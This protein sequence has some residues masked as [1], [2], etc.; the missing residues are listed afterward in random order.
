MMFTTLLL[1]G[2]GGLLVLG[3]FLQIK[4][5]K[6]FT[7]DTDFYRTERHSLFSRLF[8]HLLIAPAY[9]LTILPYKNEKFKICHKEGNVGPTKLSKT[10]FWA[11]YGINFFALQ[12]LL[13]SAAAVI[14][15]SNSDSSKVFPFLFLCMV[16]YSFYWKWLFAPIALII[17]I[18]MHILSYIY[19]GAYNTYELTVII[20]EFALHPGPAKNFAVIYM[21]L[22]VLSLSLSLSPNIVSKLL[23]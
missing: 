18:V 9:T 15:F 13:V 1:V 23:E 14:W 5:F 7:G 8:F 2:V 20:F 21:G 4:R 16:A 6:K 11:A 22:V 17:G 10:E 3:V 19:S 12:I